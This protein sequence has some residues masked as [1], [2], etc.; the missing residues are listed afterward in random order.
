MEAA[1][2]GQS[3]S[4][5]AANFGITKGEVSHLVAKYR[6]TGNTKDLPRSGCLTSRKGRQTD[7]AALQKALF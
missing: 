4:A 2:T 6:Q 3:F 1:E 7:H 5:I